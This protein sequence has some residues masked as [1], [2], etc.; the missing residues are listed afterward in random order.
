MKKRIIATILVVVMT[1]LSLASCGGTGYS[2][3]DEDMGQYTDGK[4]DI[5]AFFAALKDI[6]IKDGDF[7]TDKA[8]NDKAV[9]EDIYES[10]ASAVI[11][12][13]GNDYYSDDKLE[14]G[15][16]EE[17]DIVYFCYYA[18]DKD[19]KTYLLSEMNEANITATKYK[20]KHFIKLGNYNENDEFT[21]KLAEALLAKE[22]VKYYSM[23]DATAL[24][25]T[26]A[27]VKVGKKDII[28]V[29]YTLG[30]TAAGTQELKES[31]VKYET[32]DLG[33]SDT[34]LAEKLVALIDDTKATVNVGAEV[35]FPEGDSTNKSVTLTDA[36]GNTYKYTDV[37][38]EYK[39]DKFVEEEYAIQVVFKE[40]KFEDQAWKDENLTAE[41]KKELEKNELTYYIY[42]TYRLD[43]PE[44][45]AE[46]IIE[47]VYGKKVS[48]TSN[49]LFTSED[50]KYVEGKTETT[51]K[52]LVTALS[53]LWNEKFEKD[54]DLAKLLDKYEEAEKK[55]DEAKKEDLD[56]AEKDL[57][58]AEKKLYDEKRK[59]IRKTIA[60]IT[61]A[62]NEDEVLGEVLYEKY[63]EDSRHSLKEKYNTE[64]TEAVGKAVWALIDEMVKVTSYP[65][66]LVDEFKAHL[67]ESYEH[68]FY[69]GKV[70]SASNAES[71]YKKHGTLEKFLLSKFEGINDA[72]KIDEKVTEEA[73]KQLKPIIQ[74]YFVSQQI[75]AYDFGFCKTINGIVMEYVERDIAAGIYKSHYEYN[76]ALSKEDNERAAAKAAEQAEATK[77]SARKNARNF[78]VTNEVFEEYKK[79]MGK[80]TYE[81]WEEQYGEINIRASLQLEKLFYFLVSTDVVMTED[82]D[83]AHSEVKYV[84]EDGKYWLSFRT[85]EYNFNEKTTEESK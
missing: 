20:D 21:K 85:V 68:D 51:V 11:T 35:K 45:N 60:K 75:N 48:S 53:D 65:E 47:Y 56:K 5:E 41:Q 15:D 54:S 71:N 55:V 39:V 40:T 58:A 82:G 1:V 79:E 37:K 14:K 59:E 64:I 28:V 84:W 44:V 32:I 6:S 80:K 42:P 7:T 17:G 29:S 33:T 61:A 63:D 2:F 66:A 26:E 73:K 18:K 31:K 69:N 3:A 24:K 9:L 46:S 81:V 49:E 8:T 76:D 83:H 4:F 38:I 70:S 77:A 67:Y 23:Q 34:L 43:V 30:Y 57:E 74:I 13:A 19:G 62:K 50:Y 10:I 16:I 12:E 52:D 22:G 72:S 25:K 27:G 78:L 36:K